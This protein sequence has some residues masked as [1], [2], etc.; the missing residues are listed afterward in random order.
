MQHQEMIVHSNFNM[1]NF[2]PT[3]NHY[4]DEFFMTNYPLVYGVFIGK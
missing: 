1:M 4:F 3:L 2:M